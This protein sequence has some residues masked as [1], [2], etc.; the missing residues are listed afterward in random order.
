MNELSQS[1]EDDIRAA[2][3]GW[4]YAPVRCAICSR[5]WVA[6]YP[7]ECAVR[8]LE[9]PDCGQTGSTVEDANDN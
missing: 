5:E 4:S 2:E 8:D 9:C 7:V 1:I 6:V 3:P